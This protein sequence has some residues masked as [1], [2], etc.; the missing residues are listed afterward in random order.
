M[1]DDVSKV[2]HRIEAL[3]RLN[4]QFIKG[5]WPHWIASNWRKISRRSVSEPGDFVVVAI[6]TGYFAMWN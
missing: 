5:L 1:G 3:V 2:L 6:H 4:V